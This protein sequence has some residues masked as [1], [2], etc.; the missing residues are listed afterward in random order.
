MTKKILFSSISFQVAFVVICLA[1]LTISLSVVSADEL[2]YEYDE[3]NRLKKVTYENGAVIAYEYD[4]VGNRMVKSVEDGGGPGPCLACHASL[5]ALDE[6]WQESFRTKVESG[7]ISQETIE[8]M[9]KIISKVKED[10]CHDRHK[11]DMSSFYRFLRKLHVDLPNSS[12][13]SK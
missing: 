7:E 10:P 9:L 6:N 3:L 2:T 13:R 4:E 5:G 8:V 11:G 1:V 12:L